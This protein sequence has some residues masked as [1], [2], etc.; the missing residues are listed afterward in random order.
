[1]PARSGEAGERAA[2]R[3]LR[4]LGMTLLERN[5]RAAGGEID[6]LAYDRGTIVIVEVKSRSTNA[7]GTAAEAVTARK[8]RNLVRAARAH[9]KGKGLL[10]QPRRYDVAVVDLDAKGRAVEVRWTKAAFDETEAGG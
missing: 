9:L 7:P 4:R 1:M 6:L 2:E 10:R 8:R 5:L 3:E